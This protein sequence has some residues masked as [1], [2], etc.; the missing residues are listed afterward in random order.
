MLC[1]EIPGKSAAALLSPINHNKNNKDKT[2]KKKRHFK[3]KPETKTKTGIGI[4][5]MYKDDSLGCYLS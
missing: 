2:H 4:C 1:M 3:I 5:N